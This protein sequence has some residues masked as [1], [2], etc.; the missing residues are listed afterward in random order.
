MVIS[1]SKF[2]DTDVLPWCWGPYHDMGPALATGESRRRRALCRA[3]ALHSAEFSA[4]ET[5]AHGQRLT[6]TRTHDISPR[7]SHLLHRGTPP[8]STLHCRLNV[9]ATTGLDLD[10]NS[11]T[12]TLDSTLIFPAGEYNTVHAQMCFATE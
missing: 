4:P 8:L 6:H 7:T 11:A 1:P 3:S 10:T 9:D 12:L 5:L 2:S